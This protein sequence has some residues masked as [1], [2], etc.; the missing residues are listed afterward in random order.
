M[1]DNN[2]YTNNYNMFVTT[3]LLK[4]GMVVKESKTKYTEMRNNS[5]HNNETWI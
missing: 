1:I 3:I 2:Q 5:N 4:Y